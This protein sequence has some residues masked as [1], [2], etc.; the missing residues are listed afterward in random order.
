MIRNNQQNHTIRKHTS[1]ESCQRRGGAKPLRPPRFMSH[2]LWGYP[3]TPQTQP[4]TTIGSIFTLPKL[5][6]A[7][8]KD[9]P[10]LKKRH[11]TH[12]DNLRKSCI[13]I[14]IISQ[15]ETTWPLIDHFTVSCLVAWPL[16]ESEAGGDLV[17]IET[18]LLF[19]C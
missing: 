1:K 6:S 3:L 13:L 19:S 2:V 12:Q 15:V 11:I 5:H 17:L 8:F 10:M 14:I 16:N 4:P 9:Q 7:T 18:S